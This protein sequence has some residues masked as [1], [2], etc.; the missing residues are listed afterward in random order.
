MSVKLLLA[1]FFSLL[2]PVR[3]TGIATTYYF[4]DG[5]SGDTLGCPAEAKRLLGS[6]RFR[7]GLPVIATRD[8]PRC[9]TLVI[10]ENVRTGARTTA[11]RVD[12]GP[13]GCYWPDGSRT[14]ERACVGGRRAAIADLTRRV[15]R[16]I[17]ARGHEKVNLR[18]R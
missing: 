15:A 13:Y 6:S 7:P 12:A 10:V 17:G 14:V 4:G 8:T 5:H 3:L 11:I 9:G 18:W 16:E 1:A 2:P